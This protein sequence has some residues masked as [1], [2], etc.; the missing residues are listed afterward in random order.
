[1]RW[2]PATA[3]LL[4]LNLYYFRLDSLEL[5]ANSFCPSTEARTL[6]DR[7]SPVSSLTEL[8]AA[9]VV[10]RGLKVGPED[11]TPQLLNYLDSV[12]R[13]LCGKPVWNNV[14]TALVTMDL[15]RV[16]NQI[17]AGGLSTVCIEAQ[18]CSTKCL[19]IFKNNPYAF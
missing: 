1:M 10:K 14:I 4:Y 2:L 12:M 8:C 18:L 7:L 17:S 19:N 9:T 3:T 5:S 6:R 11:V 15:S 16:A 13:C